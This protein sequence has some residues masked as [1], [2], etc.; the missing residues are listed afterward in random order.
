MSLESIEER[1]RKEEE[2]DYG[3][4]ICLENSGFDFF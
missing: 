3:E 2:T 1:E 4:C